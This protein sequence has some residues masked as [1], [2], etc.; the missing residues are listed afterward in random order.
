[1]PD[2][3]G[4]VQIFII[5][6]RR[7]I[8]DRTMERSKAIDI[9]RALAVLLVLG[10]HLPECPE[11]TSRCFH[12]FT[13]VW[14]CGGWLGVD[15][16]FVLSGFLVSGL[17]FREQEKYGKIFAGRFL[18]RRGF[19]I[20]P[21]F[22]LLV[23]VTTVVVWFHKHQFEP[24]R[25]LAELFF[26][27]NY[28]VGLW[29]LTWSLAVEEHF[30]LLLA[31]L[32][33]AL[34]KREK[35]LNAFREIPAAFLAVAILCFG[36]RLLTWKLIPFDHR[37]HM[38]PTHLRIDSLFFGVL[39]SYIYHRQPVDFLATARRWRWA[40]FL[41]GILLLSPAFIFP[42]E[43]TPFIFTAGLTEFYLGSGCLLAGLLGMELPR[44]RLVAAA[45]YVG[46]HSYSIYLWHGGV[47]QWLT[48]FVTRVVLRTD[49]WFVGAAVY[50]IGS[51]VVGILLALAVEFPVLRLRDRWF[52]S[53]SRPLEAEAQPA[54]G[55]NG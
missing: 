26:V 40:F 12:A 46:S 28:F 5:I 37:S 1:L 54:G 25:I 38:F 14:N 20:Y 42:V 6:S 44:T 2:L 27:Q 32:L 17:L 39:I 29:G 3:G 15:L 52:P 50:L 35:T 19:K 33:W 30:Y 21:A 18:I 53:R 41:A 7:F 43:S 34:S 10:R 9:L 45:A 11:T 13:S 49:N 22:W 16:F 48:L 47:Q 51:V 23:G 24:A 55:L 36:F 8:H 4:Y 31:A